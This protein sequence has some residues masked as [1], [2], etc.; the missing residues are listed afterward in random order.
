MTAIA[1]AG[2]LALG[3]ALAA[4]AWAW[5]R[6]RHPQRLGIAAEGVEGRSLPAVGARSSRVT[7][8]AALGASQARVHD[9]VR[10]DGE[11]R[12]VEATARGPSPSGPGRRAIVGALDDHTDTVRDRAERDRLADILEATSDLVATLEPDGRIGW[13]NSAGKAALRL[14][15]EAVGHRLEA[16]LPPETA[17]TLVAEVLAAVGDGGVW[18]GETVVRGGDGSET[19]FSLVVLAHPGDDDTV[20]RFSVIARDIS[21]RKDL[22][23]QLS[24]LALRDPLTGL[25]NRTLLLDRLGQSLARA[26]RTGAPTAVLLFDVDRF[27][28]VNDSLGHAAGDALLRELAARITAAIRPGDT[29]ARFGGDEFAVVCEDLPEHRAVTLADRI[30]GALSAPLRLAEAPHAGL[31]VSTSA[32]IAIAHAG[33]D[34]TTVLGEADSAMYRAKA[35]RPGSRR[36]F[37][38]TVRAA[39]QARLDIESG[40][41]AAVA[42]GQLRLH[43]QPVIDLA[44]GAVPTVEALVRWQHPTHGLLG[45]GS[46]IEVA[47]ECGAIVEIGA[48]VLEQAAST[49]AS[50]RATLPEAADLAVGVNLS[51]EQI[52][53]GG[54]VERV[55]DVLARTGLPPSALILEITETTMVRD[56]EATVAALAALHERGVRLALDDFGT[57]YAPL[58]HLRQLPV[59]IV[60]VDRSFVAGMLGGRV[61]DAIVTA[62]VEL[63]GG[64]GLGL[65]AEGVEEREHADRLA[66]LGYRYAQGFCFSPP[67]DRAAAAALVGAAPAARWGAAG[68]D[69]GDHAEAR[70]RRDGVAR[71]TG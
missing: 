29:A 16:F 45:P 65:I 23:E 51:V 56:P 3:A 21:R 46:F 6:R 69:V 63:T 37:D 67:V 14:T 41:A 15:D 11:E 34:P 33:D 40:L 43:Y 25:A 53:A 70:Q 54:L 4:L 48:W 7:A 31:H 62:L 55:D 35:T 20:Q 24:H 42:D 26:T 22:E 44:T 10:A 50:W 47:E 38:E 28:L 8:S 9:L 13:M 52:I 32:G 71:R 1:L 57:G 30:A 60:K 39:Q 59:D 36:V 68:V 5:R 12:L 64:L 61:D 19:P 49:V 17:E 66:E 27:K 18:S 58:T 2:G